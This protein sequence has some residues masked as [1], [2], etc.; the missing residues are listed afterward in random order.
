MKE[1]WDILVSGMR[2]LLDASVDAK[3]LEK[4]RSLIIEA[5]EVSTLGEVV[6]RNSG[7]YLFAEAGLTFRIA[8]LNRAHQACQRI[9]A[10]IRQEIPT[11]TG[12]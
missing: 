5:P 10:K 8:D 9:E 2:V 4:I 7:R 12:C 1:G 11:L 3:T 6:A